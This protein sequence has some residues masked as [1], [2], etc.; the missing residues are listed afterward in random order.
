MLKL[1]EPESRVLPTATLTQTP[2]TP[3]ARG[4]IE[5]DNVS[6]EFVTGR[7]RLSAVAPTTLRISPGEFVCLLGPSGCGKST[8]LN[9]VAGHIAAKTG[10]VVIDGDVVTRPGPDR[11][12]VFQHYSLFPWRTV[13]D[14]VS[15]GPLMA[16]KSWNVANEVASKFLD[17]VGLSKFANRYP[18]ELSGGMQQRVG[19]A[20]ALANVPSV[21]LMDEP[22]GA[23][24]SQTRLMMQESLLKIWSEFRTTVLFVTHDI[25]EAIFLSDRVLLMS[26]AP[27]SVIDE[28]AIDLPRP[29][30]QNVMVDSRFIALKKRCFDRIRRESIKAFEQQNQ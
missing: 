27:G 25:D 2:G 24:D 12:V 1:L 20:R 30:T 18:A 15:F 19:I 10:R 6:V 5:I 23:L 22:F 7:L 16:G 29:R 9:V 13:R 14:N 26:A 8:L 4:D 11:G 17:M 3:G 28:I 21:L